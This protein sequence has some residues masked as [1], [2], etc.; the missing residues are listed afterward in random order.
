VAEE[1]LEGALAGPAAVAVHDDGDVLGNLIG[2]ELIVYAALFWRELMQP[3]GNPAGIWC[4]QSNLADLTLAHQ[5]GVRNESAAD[6]VCGQWTAWEEE[7]RGSADDGK[8]MLPRAGRRRLSG[9]LSGAATSGCEFA[10]VV[11]E[12]GTLQ[13][14]EL[15]GVGGNLGEERV[16]HENRCLVA[17][18]GVGVAQQGRDVYL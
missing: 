18:A 13:R 14:V 4:A 8:S 12:D 7:R 9:E 16:G 10:H 17:V 2:I 6:G 5:D 3:T 11:E 1:A 15:R